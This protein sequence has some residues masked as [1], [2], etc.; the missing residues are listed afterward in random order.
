M[1]DGLALAF[2]GIC[3]FSI[4]ERHWQSEK[5]KRSPGGAITGV[6]RRNLVNHVLLKVVLG[7]KFCM[8]NILCNR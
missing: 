5:R 1:A 2:L 3:H 6:A 7:C 8:L 4:S